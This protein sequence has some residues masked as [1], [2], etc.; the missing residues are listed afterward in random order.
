MELLEP[1]QRVGDQEVAHLAAAEVEHERA[2]VGLLAAARV[3]VLV[4]RGAVE[5]GQRPL[6]AREVRRHPVHDH[7]VAVLVQVVDEV[8]EVVRGAEA[9]GRRVVGGDLVAPGTAER[10]LGHRQQLDVGEAGLVEVVDQL[11]GQLAVAQARPPRA[12]VHLVDA[13][14]LGVRPAAGARASIQS[15]SPQ[16]WP[17]CVDDRRGGRRDLGAEG[18]R[19]GLVAPPAVLAE[20]RGTCTGCRRRCPG[21]NSSHTPVLP[22]D[23]HR[24]RPAGPAVEVAGDAHALRGRRPHREA[25]AG[26]GAG[27]GVVAAMCAPSTSQSRSWRPSPIRCR[28]MSPRVGSQRYGSS[29][30]VDARRRSARPAGSPRPGRARPR[31]TGRRRAPW[32][33]GCPSRR[34]GAPRATSSAC[35]R[36]VRTTVPSACGCAPSTECGSW[37]APPSSRSIVC[38]SGG[39]GSVPPDVSLLSGTA[40]A[41]VV[42]ASGPSTLSVVGSSVVG[43]VVAGCARHQLGRLRAILVT[44]HAEHPIAPNPPVPTLGRSPIGVGHPFPDG[45]RSV[46]TRSGSTRVSDVPERWRAAVRRPAERIRS[47][48]EA[49]PPDQPEAWSPQRGEECR[50]RSAGPARAMA[51]TRPRSSGL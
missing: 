6:V 44:I 4:E 33:S 39:L 30:S 31:R 17:E 7:A 8:A 12:E 42:T 41:G 15:S 32:T 40:G 3:G 45:Q 34:P 24:V 50:R 37:W 9:G 20:D 28:S 26:D 43:P 35:G 14:R 25:G 1:V 36:R 13:H 16:T 21:T 18:H 27:R 47:L 48:E 46:G 29:T 2:P 10:V 49:A 22:S 51:W 38:W 11:V 5:A 19:V 23:A